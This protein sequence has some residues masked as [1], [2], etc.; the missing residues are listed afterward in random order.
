MRKNIPFLIPI[1]EARFNMIKEAGSYNTF[2]I[3]LMVNPF[4]NEEDDRV[5]K[6]IL[7]P[8]DTIIYRETLDIIGQ[9]TDEEHL[10]LAA[11]KTK[12]PA[13]A[14][15]KDESL[16][17]MCEILAYDNL[18]YKKF[19]LFGGTAELK[20]FFRNNKAFNILPVPGYEVP[21]VV[22]QPLKNV[23]DKMFQVQ[24]II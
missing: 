23:N 8:Q 15:D 1:D 17:Y 2:K 22:I 13:L 9:G 7:E 11:F 4:Q 12:T 24:P 20:E 5:F 3:L 6:W 14:G 16:F 10:Y 18:V 19:P 21:L